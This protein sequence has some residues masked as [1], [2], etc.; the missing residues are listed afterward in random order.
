MGS[1]LEGPEST[2]WF[3]GQQSSGASKVSKLMGT[4][5]LE[6]HLPLLTRHSDTQEHTGRGMNTT[7]VGFALKMLGSA[8]T[9][10]QKHTH[11]I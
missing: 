5:I 1:F 10:T 8:R 11:T 2:L 4:Q 7:L 6:W 3:S 9:H